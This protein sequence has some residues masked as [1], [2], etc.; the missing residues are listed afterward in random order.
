MV[1]NTLPRPRNHRDFN[2]ST[3]KDFRATRTGLQPC[4]QGSPA[5]WTYRL[6]GRVTSDCT[7]APMV[8]HRSENRVRF[9]G[10]M[11]SDLA[12]DGARLCLNLA[13]ILDLLGGGTGGGNQSGS[14]CFSL[15]L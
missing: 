14:F 11:P 8:D 7:P 3:A 10:H 1:C 13:A 4:V 5:G 15:Q 2:T 6:Q 9:G 12:T